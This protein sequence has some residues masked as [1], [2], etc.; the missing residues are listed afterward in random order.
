[1]KAFKTFFSKFIKRKNNDPTSSQSNSPS[2]KD[3]PTGPQSAEPS[4]NDDPA[5][6]LSV[7]SSRNDDGPSA[8]NT[9]TSILRTIKNVTDSIG[10][11]VLSTAIGGLSKVL[12]SIEVCLS[13]M[14]LLFIYNV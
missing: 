12:G 7:A 14:Y 3:D 6:S 8:L 1:M 4:N 10:L 9:F 13:C 5:D 2:K 11:P